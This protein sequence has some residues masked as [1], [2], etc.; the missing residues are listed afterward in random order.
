M[1]CNGVHW[2]SNPHV[3]PLAAAVLLCHWWPLLTIPSQ[4]L[5]A[6]GCHGAIDRPTVTV[7]VAR[8]G[9]D[10]LSDNLNLVCTSQALVA[11][12]PPRVFY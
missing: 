5:P 8:I 2:R 1:P 9:G 6:R 3:T 4:L 7:P 11:W 12:A 10:L